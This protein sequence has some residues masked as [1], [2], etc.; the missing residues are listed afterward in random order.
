[1]PNANDSRP[2]LPDNVAEEAAACIETSV[3]GATVNLLSKQ[4][5]KHRAENPY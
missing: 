3:H 2:A 1:M 4:L 5:L